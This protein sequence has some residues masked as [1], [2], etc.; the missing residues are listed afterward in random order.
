MQSRGVLFDLDGTLLDTARDLGNAL[1][2]LLVQNGLPECTYEQYR[3]IASHGSKGLIEL[4]FQS[5]LKDYDFDALRRDFLAHYEQNLCVDTR[6]F[7]GV[8]EVIEALDG[9]DIPWGIVTNKPGWLTDALLPNFPQ[10]Q[11]CRV[12][13]SGDTLAERKPH[14]LP[15][16]HAGDVLGVAPQN[17]LYVGDA[18]RDI[19]AANAASMVSV[20]AE[21]G[22]IHASESPQDW[23]ADVSITTP[24]EL[25]KHL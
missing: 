11:R 3:P 14:P 2:H 12:T 20:L 16:L 17:I 19:Q 23:Q 25:L 5:C 10:F 4:G 8:D 18:E 21:Y 9:A 24:G 22:Y 6:A 1:N 15:L 13:I 7:E